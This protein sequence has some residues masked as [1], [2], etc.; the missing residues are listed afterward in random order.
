LGRNSDAARQYAA[1]VDAP[2]GHEKAEES[3][4]RIL[5]LLSVEEEARLAEFY[6]VER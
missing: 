6:Q 2:A 3:L 5:P 4:K 1:A